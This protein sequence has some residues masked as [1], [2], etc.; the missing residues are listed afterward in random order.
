[1]HFRWWTSAAM[2][3]ACA[4]LAGCVGEPGP[5][6][7]M[8]AEPDACE[9]RLGCVTGHNIAAMVDQPSDLAVP[10][11]EGRRDSVRREAVLSAWRGNGQLSQ[12]AAPAPV[13]GGSRP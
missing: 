5:M 13:P 2:A 8:D 9:A 12:G 6:A 1:M 10:R 11:R 4:L 7:L 3:G